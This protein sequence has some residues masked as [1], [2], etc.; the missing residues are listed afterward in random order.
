MQKKLLVLY[1]LY[2][3]T[4]ALLREK[5]KWSQNKNIPFNHTEILHLNKDNMKG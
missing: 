5:Q 4:R 1:F 2:H 3:F